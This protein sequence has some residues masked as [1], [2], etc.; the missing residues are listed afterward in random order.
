MPR[1]L[2]RIVRLPFAVP[3][4]V[5]FTTLALTFGLAEAGTCT[6]DVPMGAIAPARPIWCEVL[7]VGRDTHTA[8]GN[9]WSDDFNH[10]QS[11]ATL[12]TAYVEGF[13]GNGDVRHFQHNEHWMLDIESTG[14]GAL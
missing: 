12:N 1:D 7:G 13:F 9:S 4:I 14:S 6:S 3:L 8:G 2:R 5:L 10:G 11:M